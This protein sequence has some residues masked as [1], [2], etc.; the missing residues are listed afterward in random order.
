ME[1]N[2]LI[3]S[4]CLPTNGVIEWVFPVL[5]SIYSQNVDEKQFEVIV[6]DNGNNK[7]FFE[8]MTKYV[9]LHDNLIY[10]KTTAYQFF[11]Q[12]EALKIA[13]GK[14]LKFVNHRAVLKNG[15]LEKMIRFVEENSK[16]KPVI[17]FSNGTIKPKNNILSCTSF[18]NFIYELGRW[19]SW[20]TGVGIW[21][22][23][24]DKIPIDV[25]IDK[26]S[27]HSMILFSER[28][29]KE[30]LINNYVFFQE[31]DSSHKQ[32]GKYDLF[33]AFA[34]E[35]LTITL[36]LYIDNDISARTLIHVKNEYKKFVSALYWKFCICKEPCSYDLNGFNESMG[37]YFSKFSIIL[38]AWIY[39]SK[40]FIK[41]I[42]KNKRRF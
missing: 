35:E 14:Y 30:Y 31:I 23:D 26:I 34:V 9:P 42:I 21:K 25:K 33:K 28:Q 12:L 20:T 41:K 17:Y 10:R 11:N 19:A 24:Y 32:K 7:E 27:P 8:K 40:M 2:N 39:G 6:T 15:S 18:D 37:I 29:K 3:L 1:T 5:E 13:K 38:G 22:E 36:N 16:T 4:L